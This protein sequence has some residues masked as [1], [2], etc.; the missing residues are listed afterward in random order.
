[1]TEKRD[2]E[3]RFLPTRTFQICKILRQPRHREQK[4]PCPCAEYTFTSGL[5]GTHSKSLRNLANIMASHESLLISA[6]RL[7]RNRI[8]RYC[9]SCPRSLP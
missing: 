1:M 5:N 2:L 3:H 8:N 6:M 4:R 9:R 7:D